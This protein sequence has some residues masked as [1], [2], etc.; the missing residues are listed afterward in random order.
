MVVQLFKKV[1]F[2]QFWAYLSKKSKSIKAIY[3]DASERY[4]F[5]LSET[6]NMLIC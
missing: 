6:G 2:L 5:A 1:Y 4:C 3:T